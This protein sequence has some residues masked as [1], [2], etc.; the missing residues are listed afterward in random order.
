VSS[1]RDEAARR[2]RLVLITPGDRAADETLQVVEQALRGGVT[3][4]LLREPQLSQDARNFLAQELA[5]AAREA[6]AWLV[7]HN[8]VA[9][10]L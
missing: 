8:D 2:L 1:S 10:A 5:V 6:G 9:L 7:V 3:A 4:V